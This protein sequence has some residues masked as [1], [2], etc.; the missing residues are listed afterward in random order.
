MEIKTENIQEYLTY[1]GSPVRD[2]FPS[3]NQMVYGKPLV[4]L[5]NAATTQKP[6]KVI[7][8]IQEYYTTINSNIH[9]GVH[10]LSQ[11]ATDAYEVSRNSV[12][13]FIN[14]RNSREIIFTRGTTEGINLV[15]DCFSRYGISEKDSI[16]I[17]SFEHHSNIVPWQMLCDKTGARLKVIPMNEDGELLID[18]YK[19]L[20][21]D[22]V[23]IVAVSYVSNTLGTINPV[24][25][26]TELAHQ[27]GS[28]VLIDA[29]QA[30]QHLAIN[31]QELN[32]DFLA[33]SGH[34]MYGPTG[35]GILYGKEEWLEK[36][37]PYQ[38]GGDMIKTVT[39][40]KTEYNELP[41]KFEAGT[42]HI[43]GA[44]TLKA[45]I[46]FI[47][48]I[49][50]NEIAAF[51]QGLMEYATAAVQEIPGLNIIGK[52]KAKTGS[53]SLSVQGAHPYDI[54]VLLDKMG[55]AVRTGHHCTQP[56]MDFF[57]IP[58]TVRASFALY[59]TTSEI[60]TFVTGLKR[61]IN[62]LV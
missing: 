35:I 43:E 21:D 26:I 10:Y 53:L 45:A 37:P 33:F 44:I 15:A 42:P 3:L 4:Y 30:V 5:D 20:L 49:G 62:M 55:I 16:I 47:K 28:V 51:E 58:G 46:D 56:I 7:N 29:A 18:E 22:T 14:A 13:E 34:K 31:V 61:A 39:F 38:G 23:K 6:W 19:A 9:R 11:K 24:K 54:G 17:S 36:L 32:C 1:N 50:I 52:A 60:D 59:N 48:E 2:Q 25:E 57:C 27:N 8:A 41:F 40:V 12:A